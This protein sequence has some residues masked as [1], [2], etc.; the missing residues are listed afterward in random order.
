MVALSALT[1]IIMQ[2]IIQQQVTDSKIAESVI[3]DDMYG[4]D[5]EEVW[6]IFLTMANTVITKEM[7]SKGVLD[8][9]AIDCRTVLRRALLNN[10]G[11]IVLVHNHPSGNPLPSSK[12]IEF[13]KKLKGSCTLMDIGL[14]DHII[15]AGNS[16]YSFAD[17]N[18]YYLEQT[19]NEQII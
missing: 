11:R 15:I 19:K 6:V 12:D 10:A 17:E 4:L 8:S 7:A 5:H 13:T 3:H 16:F 1:H 18:P 14:L 9:T 2:Y